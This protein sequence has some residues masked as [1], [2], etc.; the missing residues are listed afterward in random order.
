MCE[1]SRNVRSCAWDRQGASG[2]FGV[3]IIGQM[4]TGDVVVSVCWGLPG[5]GKPF[6]DC[7]TST[8]PGPCESLKSP[9]LDGMKGDTAG[10][11]KGA[12]G[13]DPCNK[14]ENGTR[15]LGAVNSGVFACLE[16]KPAKNS[17]SQGSDHLLKVRCML[18][19]FLDQSHYWPLIYTLGKN[20]AK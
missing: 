5:Q 8:C 2:S 19:A 6:S 15:R 9:P 4:S 11:E 18:K 20:H 1:S 3:K 7:F 16:H 13:I 12:T 14:E 10:H 17:K